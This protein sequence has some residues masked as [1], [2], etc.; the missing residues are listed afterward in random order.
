MAR[1]RSKSSVAK[2]AAAPGVSSL[3]PPVNALLSLREIDLIADPDERRRRM[4]DRL[5]QIGKL[6]AGRCYVNKRGTPVATPDTGTML[7]VE[8]VGLEVLGIHP[9]R[10]VGKVA[11]FSVF[12]GGK[13]AE[14]K[15]G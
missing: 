8:E 2:G 14:K 9:A 3:Q 1:A 11:D 13:A 6:A 10:V 4:L 15:A 12:N 7:R 5:E